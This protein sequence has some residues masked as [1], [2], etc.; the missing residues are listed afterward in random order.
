MGC[1]GQK[2][3]PAKD[4][5]FVLDSDHLD[6]IES[7]LYGFA[8]RNGR[9]AESIGD[10]EGSA[11]EKDGAYVYI[12]RDQNRITIS[13]DYAGCFGLYLFRKAGYFALS[14]SQLLLSEYVRERYP[15]TLNREYADYLLAADL[16]SAVYGETMIREISE[17]DRCAVAE[18][19]IPQKQINLRYTDYRENTVDPGSAEGIAILDAWREKWV[20]RIRSIYAN[21]E[22]IRE[23]LSGGFDSRETLALFL[24]SGI[25]LNRILVYTHTDKLHTHK[26]DYEIA[27]EIAA[28]CGFE[29]NN[30]QN[31]IRRVIPSGTEEVLI[32]SLYAKLG[33]HKQMYFKNEWNTARLY[34]FT[35]NGG[36]CIRDYWRATEKE[37]IEGETKHCDIFA[38]S[39]RICD[40]MKTSTREVL[41]RSVEAMR[42]H[43]RETGKPIAEE[44]L[45]STLYRETRCRN[46]FG[47]Q[48]VEAY[49]ANIIMLSPLMDSDLYKLKLA[50][51]E[52]PDR[53]LLS[54]LIL[55]R[56]APELTEIRFDSGKSIK[57][58]TAKYVRKLC[59]QYPCQ[60]MPEAGIMKMPLSG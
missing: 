22:N 53:N 10:L 2:A 29:L 55:E 38:G 24:S 40:R 17:L 42:A 32:R 25:D 19:D 60:K 6:S 44:D 43:F 5:F 16:C 11:P 59:G 54:A 30:Q 56:Y 46:H 37:Y 49:L 36:E 4:L 52:C 39:P 15:V 57:P 12:H 33:F 45:M 34:T 26:E 31:V 35:G 48:I 7:R 28:R 3:R 9:I 14:N 50:S 23:D 41:S 47:K 8:F 58:E 51:G 13:Q 27:L 20:S 18:I 1:D 21:N